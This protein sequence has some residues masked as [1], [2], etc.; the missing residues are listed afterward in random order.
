MFELIF[1]VLIYGIYSLDKMS[2]TVEFKA[3]LRPYVIVLGPYRRPSL[4]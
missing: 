1:G 4:I 3:S 2:D